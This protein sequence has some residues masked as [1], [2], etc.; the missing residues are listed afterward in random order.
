MQK[1]I[2]RA[3]WI[4]CSI[5]LC[6]IY[7]FTNKIDFDIVNIEYVEK[8]EYQK[9]EDDTQYF[10][11]EITED[12]KG[13]TIS[14]KTKNSIVYAYIDDNLIYSFDKTLNIGKSPGSF[15]H[16][17]EIPKEEEGTF[18]IKINTV[19][20]NDFSEN[21]QFMVGENSSILFKLLYDEIFSLIINTVLIIIS[22]TMVIN[23]F[24]SK[25]DDKSLFNLG[26][27]T[28]FLTIW[29]NS[30]NFISQ[31]IFKNAIFNYYLTYFS[32]FYSY[33]MLLTYFMSCGLKLKKEYIVLVSSTVI[34]I[35]L[36]FS[37][38]MDFT[39]SM[40]FVSIIMIVILISLLI[41]LIQSFKYIKSIPLKVS[42]CFLILFIIVSIGVYSLTNS[43]IYPLLTKIGLIV[44][45][46]FYFYYGIK[47]IVNNEVI[48]EKTQLL[49][50]LAFRDEL[51][52]IYNRN[53][54]KSYIKNK[55]IE[56]MGIVSLDLNNLKYYNDN[57]GHSYGDQL[58]LE[59][60]R[61]LT[62]T[63]GEAHIFRVGGDEFL[64]VYDDIQD[65]EK[66]LN[67]KNDLQTILQR[68]N[69]NQNN[70]LV[71]EI[72]IGYAWYSS[73][74][75]S[76]EDILKRADRYMYINKKEIKQKSKIKKTR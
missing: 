57:F 74:D 20:K 10:S 62:Q 50:K 3:M 14:F 61:I 72:A 21:Y 67:L 69:E 40:K 70:G 33:L 37:T 5:L 71:L 31:L 18:T 48:A 27:L 60:S 11:T 28:I 35:I 34:S 17:I 58:I 59:A 53:A 63:F 75:K 43:N 65:K 16:F 45:L 55:D 39:E 42:S 12:L 30:D 38:I 47:R 73:E 4:F 51:T 54:L 22:L 1:Y 15:Q 44:F 36:H 32:F 7:L 2:N 25:K 56:N 76:Y 8:W 13:K 66:L 46:L 41:K 64:A 24:I 29:T 68:Y 6:M 9:T 49:E 23:S 19:Y 52:K 26:L